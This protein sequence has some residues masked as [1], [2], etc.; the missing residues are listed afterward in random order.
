MKNEKIVLSY[1]RVRALLDCE[2]KFKFSYV[3][4]LEKIQWKQEYLMGNM[5]QLGIFLLMSGKKDV[6]KIVKKEFENQVKDL[7][8]TFS[9]AIGDEQKLVE[10]QIMLIGMIR[11]YAVKYV[12]DLQIEKHIKNEHDVIYSFN[13]IA[14]IRIKMDNIIA[15]KDKWCLHEGKA[16]KSL[17]PNIVDSVKNS[18]QIAIYFHIYNSFYTTKKIVDQLGNTI[19]AKPFSNIIFDAVQKPSI[20]KKVGEVY[21]E[22]LKRLEGYYAGS[23]SNTKFYK[24]FIQPAISKDDV[25]RTLS[26]SSKRMLRLYEG[27]RP[28]KSFNSCNW[29]DYYRLCFE[30]KNKKTIA[31]YRSK[32]EEIE[33]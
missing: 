2:Q 1:S 23:D 33:K 13:D 18:L 21:K 11:G 27:K 14:D 24:E 32:K 30:G 17:N 10:M 15:V 22:Y 25:F 7:R 6:E 19:K 31:D 26:I 4:R 28:L 20:R 3:D 9:L 29:C 8:K 12:K 16:W 5:F